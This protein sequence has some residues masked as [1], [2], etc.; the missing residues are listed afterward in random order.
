LTWL[1]LP[2]AKRIQLGRVIIPASQEFRCRLALAVDPEARTPGERETLE[3]RPPEGANV[4]IRQLY[5][6]L[7]V[8]RF[9]VQTKF[10]EE[11]KRP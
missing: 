6:G 3:G 7:E 8:G 2:P 10:R 9:T 11:G 5:R 4:A 1:L